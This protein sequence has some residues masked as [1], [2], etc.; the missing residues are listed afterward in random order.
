MTAHGQPG[1]CDLRCEKMRRPSSCRL[2]HWQLRRLTDFG[3]LFRSVPF[4]SLSVPIPLSDVRRYCKILIF[5]RYY[6]YHPI[7]TGIGKI[8]IL[9]DMIRFIQWTVWNNG[10]THRDLAKKTHA[11]WAN[12]FL[13][14]TPK[15]AF[16]REIAQWLKRLY[17]QS[18]TRAFGWLQ[19]N[20]LH[21]I[22]IC[23]AP[24]TT[25][26]CFL[27]LLSNLC[28]PCSIRV[29]ISLCERLG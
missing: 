6:R 12:W 27:Q 11:Q 19:C 10:K 4:H 7:L 18:H 5:N 14:R 8:H 13:A 25:W 2:W 17:F 28:A 3:K 16:W 20:P 15:L 29:S 21:R 1:G 22:H 26:W 23:G 9:S 24:G